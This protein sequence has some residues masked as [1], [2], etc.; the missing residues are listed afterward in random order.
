MSQ[1]E[2]VEDPTAEATP[3][4]CDAKPADTDLEL[5]RGVGPEDGEWQ[6]ASEV[7]EAF[8]P[9]P[10]VLIPSPVD[11]L[12]IPADERPGLQLAPR[13]SVD[14]L[15]CLEDR[16][17]YVE[18]FEEELL[19]E[20]ED[21]GHFA[22]SHESN[23]LTYR[24]IHDEDGKERQRRVFSASL[25]EKLYGR[26][27]VC[28]CSAEGVAMRGAIYTIIPVRPL[29]PVCEHYKRQLFNNDDQPDPNKP[30]HRILFRN[31]TARRSVGGAFL[32]LRDQ[33]VYACEHRTPADP[34]STALLDAIDDKALTEVVE[35]VPLFNLR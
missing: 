20:Y 8:V 3:P 1:D 26:D 21:W 28:V 6:A 12:P 11:G 29:R 35:E 17:R 30:G 2:L 27:V 16:R 23:L 19:D 33:A 5:E 34:T 10:I 4:E 22:Q 7:D 18:V 24:T 14:N 9:E 13:F 31:C 15:V 32:S 25:V